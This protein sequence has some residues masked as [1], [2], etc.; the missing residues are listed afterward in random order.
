MD[1]HQLRHFVALAE[2]ANFTRAAE[3]SCI[4]QSAFSRSIQTLEQDLGCRLVERS[5]RGISLT[6]QGLALQARARKLLAGAS[7]LRAEISALEM[8]ARPALRFGAGPLPA[9]RLVPDAVADFLDRH[10]DTRIE[11]RVEMPDVLKQFLN[12]GEIEFM[13]ADLR[14]IEASKG[15]VTR[16]LRTRRFQLFCRQQH[17]L[18]SGGTPAF[19]ALANYPL[20]CTTL[21]TEL[22]ILLGERAGRRTLP[23]SMECR[24]TDI[25]LR[26]VARSNTIGIVTEDVVAHTLAQ[27]GFQTLQFTDT[28]Q[29]LLDGGTCFG[30]SYCADRQLSS[31]AQRLLESICLFDELS[32]PYRAAPLGDYCLAV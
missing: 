6:T 21:P 7:S 25:L 32:Q 13:V 26:I 19:R 28:P 9:A 5:K 1:L 16:P 10:G 3:A 2:H 17:P 18:L 30:I 23:V 4:T 12:T 24:D 20:A 29:A 11:L 22:R 27:G 14:H 8:T 31:A 15:Y